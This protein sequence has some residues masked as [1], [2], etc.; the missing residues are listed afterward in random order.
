MFFPLVFGHG[1]VLNGHFIRDGRQG[2]LDACAFRRSEAQQ[3]MAPR[4]ILQVKN[5]QIIQDS[6]Q[7]TNNDGAGPLIA[8]VSM[9]GRPDSINLPIQVIQNFPGIDGRLTASPSGS[10]PYTAP[11]SYKIPE[12]LQCSGFATLP[13]GT[14]VN[15]LCLI[16]F[17]NPQRFVSCKFIRV[18]QSQTVYVTALLASTPTLEVQNLIQN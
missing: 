6:Y 2:F 5:G 18:V 7:T 13:D 12:N 10:F 1:H 14:T 16:Q 3:Y 4:N 15:N 17:K 11:I 9:M 8:M